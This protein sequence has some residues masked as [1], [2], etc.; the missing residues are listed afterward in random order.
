MSAG[1][2]L[3]PMSRVSN[4]RVAI[5]LVLATESVFFATLL[6]AYVALRGQSAWTVEHTLKRLAFPLANTGL[7]LFSMLPAGR[8]VASIRA[9]KSE[10]LRNWL[11]TTVLLGVVFILGQVYEFGHAGFQVNA[12]VMGAVFLALMGFH[13]LHV[14]AGIF[15]LLLNL[16]RTGLGDFSS[17]RHEAVTMGSWFWYYVCAVWLVLFGALYLL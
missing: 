7:L 15:F 5:F 17:E 3:H 4:A 14:L 16:V 6:V 11:I 10:A 9:G 2:G 8:A 12:Q 13:G 1:T